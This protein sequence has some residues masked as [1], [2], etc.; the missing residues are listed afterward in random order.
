MMKRSDL[1]TAAL[2]GTVTC[3]S[4]VAMGRS[5]LAICVADSLWTSALMV[6]LTCV[7]LTCLCAAAMALVALALLTGVAR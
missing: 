6:L 4:G 2:L 7:L 1:W 3:L 5:V